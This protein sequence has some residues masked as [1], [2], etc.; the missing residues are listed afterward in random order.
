M[1]ACITRSYLTPARDEEA[2]SQRKARSRQA[3]QT[4][5]STQGVTLADLR[6]AEKTF[7]YPRVE[8]RG[9]EQDRQE[10]EKKVPKSLLLPPRD[11]GE[12]SPQWTRGQ[13]EFGYW[14]PRFGS[15][16]ESPTTPLASPS[17]SGCFLFP[18]TA[19]TNRLAGGGSASQSSSRGLGRE[20]ERSGSDKRVEEENGLNDQS[21][22]QQSLQERRQSRDH[23]QETG[24]SC[25]RQEHDRTSRSDSSGTGD[26]V[27]DRLLSRTSSYTRRENRLAS[28]GKAEEEGSAKDFKKMYEDALTENVKLKSKL[29][30][31]KEELGR[32]RSQLDKVAQ[33]QNK[34]SEK[35]TVLETEKKEKR[36]LERKV[37]QMEEELKSLPQLGQVQ[38]LRQVN[39]RLVAENRAMKRVIGRL[40]RLTPLPETEDL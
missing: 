17:A 39:E 12:H 20:V 24:V 8:R 26:S 35:S 4:R 6:E 3:R 16:A 25:G 9:A 27:T 30:E 5:R 13:E 19:L 32:I 40:S 14:R 1:Q 28:L 10:E 2:E 22:L 23:S 31:S 29:E 33:K 11:P 21:E 37:S 7:G 15:Q 38:T 18:G 34:I 36:V